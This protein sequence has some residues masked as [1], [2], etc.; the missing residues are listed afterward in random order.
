MQRAVL[1]STLIGIGALTLG[2]AGE[3]LQEQGPKV[4]Q[5][6]R[7]EPNLYVLKGGGGNTT[8]FIA[9]KGVVVVDSK[10]PG[11]G[12][13]LLDKIKTLT[14]KPITT[15]INTH[16]HGDH[17]SGQV[18]F[19]GPIEV[20]AH[21]TTKANMPKLDAYKG[22]ANATFL[23][24]RTFNE[25]LSL[26]SGRDKIDLYYF[27]PGHTNG[28]AWVVFPALRIACAGDLFARKQVP[29][30]DTD[31]GGSGGAYPDTLLKA[32][33]GIKNVDTIITGHSNTTMTWR[34]LKEYADFNGDFLAWARSE[35]KAGKTAE[36]AAGEFKIP[37]KYKGYMAS[38][39]PMMYFRQMYDELE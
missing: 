20:V 8:V 37:E 19:P 11:W 31:N 16:A 15:L 18:E 24:T 33:N 14:N 39:P 28:D 13:P 27:G 38:L 1:L 6:E 7:I 29:L 36:Q 5:V 22:G 10:N 26:L 34:D 23:P 32:Y 2:V 9:A 17:V 25:T 30:V 12:Q 4:V 3:P 35:K 21:E